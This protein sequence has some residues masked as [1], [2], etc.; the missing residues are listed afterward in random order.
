MAVP[1]VKATYS[2][3]LET[4]RSLERTAKRWRVSKSEALR[5]AIHAAERAE[6]PGEQNG[7]LAAL[8]LLQQSLRLDSGAASTWQEQA[9]LERRAYS[10]R[11]G[12]KRS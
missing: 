9:R 5:R 1:K 7:A 8:D 10:S 6:L 2:L 4:V 3:D 12:P 11:R